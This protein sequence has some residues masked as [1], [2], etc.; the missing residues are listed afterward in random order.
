MKNANAW[1]QLLCRIHFLQLFPDFPR[2]NKSFLTTNLFTW[3]NKVGFL[4]CLQSHQK[5]G[6]WNKFK[7]AGTNNLRAKRAEKILNCV[8]QFKIFFCIFANFCTQ[9]L[10]NSLTFPDALSFL[11]LW[12]VKF[13]DFF[14]FFPDFTWLPL[15]A[16]TTSQSLIS[17]MHSDE[18]NERFLSLVSNVCRHFEDVTSDGKLFQVFFTAATGERFVADCGEMCHS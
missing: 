5:Q 9:I 8:Q 13:L 3:N 1:F 6:W 14:W 10:L 12:N 16:G 4:K 2:Q 15:T 7:S 11:G 18:E 17:Q